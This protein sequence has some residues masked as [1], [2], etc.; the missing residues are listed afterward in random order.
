MEF[1][2]MEKKLHMWIKF[3]FLDKMEILGIEKRKVDKQGR[4]IIPPDWSDQLGESRDVLIVKGKG[5]LKIIPLK[6]G[7]L[8]S[9]FDSV[10]LRIEP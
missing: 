8:T 10:D 1:V 2:V 4:L 5:F 9:F 3:V 7:G 6:R